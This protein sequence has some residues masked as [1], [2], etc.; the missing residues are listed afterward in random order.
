MSPKAISISWDSPFN[1][2]FKLSCSWSCCDGVGLSPVIPLDEPEAAPWWVT[3][4][5]VTSSTWPAAAST[6]GSAGFDA[7]LWG[8][9]RTNTGISAE[10]AY[11]R[12]TSMIHHP[13]GYFNIGRT[14]IGDSQVNFANKRSLVNDYQTHKHMW[15]NDITNSSRGESTIITRWSEGTKDHHGLENL[16]AIGIKAC[17]TKTDQ[18]YIWK[19]RCFG[20][21]LSYTKVQE[22]QLIKI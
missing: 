10:S 19:D 9:T 14:I 4:A 8:I 22:K 6:A 5:G 13:A 20:R 17:N 11:H 18:F 3:C 2:C 12:G 1:E 21:K 16:W 7:R 15:T